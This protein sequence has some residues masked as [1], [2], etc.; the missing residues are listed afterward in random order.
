MYDMS[1][2]T[3]C[4]HFSKRLASSLD[5]TRYW[6]II[7]R[8]SYERFLRKCIRRMGW[9][10]RPIPKSSLPWRGSKRSAWF[11]WHMY[12]I[13]MT[14]KNIACPALLGLHPSHHFIRIKHKHFLP[15]VQQQCY[16]NISLNIGSVGRKEMKLGC[17]KE[18]T[19]KVNHKNQLSI[20]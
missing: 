10:T 19:G 4:I 9:C 12:K 3:E 20:A 1:V 6:C 13:I 15:H 5:L 11:V 2:I 14:R 7:W 18:S 17:G 16:E 8:N